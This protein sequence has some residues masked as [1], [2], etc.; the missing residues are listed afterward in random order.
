MYNAVTFSGATA[1]KPILKFGRVMLLA[2]LHT[3]VEFDPALLLGGSVLPDGQLRSH[4][5]E[6]S[7]ANSS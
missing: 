3:K 7:A 2:K 6:F 5:A 4:A 1:G